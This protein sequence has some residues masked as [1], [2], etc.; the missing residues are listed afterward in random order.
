MGR[1]ICST[2]VVLLIFGSGVRIV[3]AAAVTCTAVADVAKEV[4]KAPGLALNRSGP[5]AVRLSTTAT[6]LLVAVAPKT[7]TDERPNKGNRKGAAPV[8]TILLRSP[9]K[10]EAAALP[11]GVHAQG[12]TAVAEFDLAAVRALPAGP[13]NVV[14]TTRY[15]ERSC[16]ITPK[17]RTQL[18]HSEE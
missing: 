13:F 17:Q 15:G 1:V 8:D 2:T 9:Y 12:E 6:T 4:L 7:H 16:R 3:A 18:V 14:I 10:S 11:S 5:Y